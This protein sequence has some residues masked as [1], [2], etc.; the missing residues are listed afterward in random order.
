LE[1]YSKLPTLE[2]GPLTGTLMLS[3]DCWT[4]FIFALSANQL[5]DQV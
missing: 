5:D 2:I 1:H 3:I 4:G